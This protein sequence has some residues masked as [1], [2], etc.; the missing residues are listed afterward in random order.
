MR[1]G[2]I[3]SSFS[4]ALLAMLLQQRNSVRSMN[5][6]PD[7][8]MQIETTAVS[9]MPTFIPVLWPSWLVWWCSI[10]CSVLATGWD[11][12]VI[13][14]FMF[15]KYFCDYNCTKFISFTI[16]SQIMV[17]YNYC[18]N[19]CQFYIFLHWMLRLQGSIHYLSL[20]GPVSSIWVYLAWTTVWLTE[21]DR[22]LHSKTSRANCQLEVFQSLC[23]IERLWIICLDYWSWGGWVSLAVDLYNW[24]L[25]VLRWKDFS[26]LYQSKEK[27]IQIEDNKIFSCSDSKFNS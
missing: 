4:P 12:I 26:S 13:R 9:T 6:L 8:K 5:V 23:F 17:H 10:V 19:V 20:V 16:Y 18:G 21:K 25:C 14:R 1:N 11:I 3:S 24:S 22:S 27:G 7:G 15:V 2:C